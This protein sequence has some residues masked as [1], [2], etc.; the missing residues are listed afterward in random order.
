MEMITTVKDAMKAL[1]ENKQLIG[2]P[3]QNYI[4]DTIKENPWQDINPLK[5]YLDENWE[6][7]ITDNTQREQLLTE[8]ESLG[9]LNKDT[10]ATLDTSLINDIVNAIKSVHIKYEKLEKEMEDDL[11]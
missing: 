5:P 10:L 1:L 7:I 6:Y 4:S 8:C 9:I 11:K 2:R 3:K